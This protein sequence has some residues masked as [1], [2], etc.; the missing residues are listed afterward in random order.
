MNRVP[1]CPFC[2]IVAESG[3][4]R[5]VYEDDATVAFLPLNPATPGHTLVV[6][7][8]HIAD[9]FE[10]TPLL[11]GQLGRATQRVAEAVRR[12]VNPD[13]TNL[14][15]SAGR[16]AQQTVFHL[17]VH[18]LPRFDGDRVGDIWPDDQPID[19]SEADEIQR[20]IVSA[21]ESSASNGAASSR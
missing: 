19:A 17:H 2:D 6:P 8:D 3:K 12:A 16:A 4:A 18:V 21:V 15:T 11:I 20:M 1:G 14:I 10:A 9:F 13:G 5:L 7:R